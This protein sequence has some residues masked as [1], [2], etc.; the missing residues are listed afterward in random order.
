MFLIHFFRVAGDVI[1]G[2]VAKCLNARPKTREKG[3]EII[4]MYV[5]IEKQDIVQVRVQYYSSKIFMG[6]AF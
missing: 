2:V 5:E 3:M 1:S 6:P 4:L